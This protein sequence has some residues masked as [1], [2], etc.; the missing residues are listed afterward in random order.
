MTGTSMATPIAAAYA[1]LVLEFVRQEDDTR[2]GKTPYLKESKRRIEE[3]PRGHIT[4]IFKNL[5]S[6]PS[7]SKTLHL[8]PWKFLKDIKSRTKIAENLWETICSS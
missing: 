1:A 4:K 6:V 8:A 5:M 7:D 3:N 2:N